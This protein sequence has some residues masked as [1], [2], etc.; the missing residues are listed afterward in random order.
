[1]QIPPNINI[2]IKSAV[3]PR[4]EPSSNILQYRY[5]NTILKKKLNPN[6]PKYKNVVI[7]RQN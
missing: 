1:M 2:T 4:N 7:K 6:V 3:R 5:V